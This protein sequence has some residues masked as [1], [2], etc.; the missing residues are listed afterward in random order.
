MSN[1]LII[2]AGPVYGPGGASTAG[3]DIGKVEWG[4]PTQIVTFNVG[5]DGGWGSSS[6]G[7]LAGSFRDAD[8]RI[9][10]RLL[11]SRGLNA[12][13][14]DKI[15]IAGFSA[16]HGLANPLLLSDGDS[17]DAAIL[18]DAC[19]EGTAAAPKAGY[20]DFA[21]KAARGEKLMVFLGSTGQNGPGLP[22]TSKGYECAFN[23][24]GAG[25]A[26]AGAALEEVPTPEGMRAAKCGAYRT[27]DLW[28]LNYCDL[29]AGNPDVHGGIVKHMTEETLQTLLVPYLSGVRSSGALARL[30]A[31]LGVPWWGWALGL[32]GLVGA[33][34]AGV[35]VA[36]RQ[37]R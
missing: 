7:L 2:W 14:Y 6:F 29:F 24:A 31:P 27:G 12:S 23:A 25:A 17:I 22:P 3:G 4:Q 28:V 5:P 10:P 32:A 18:L 21:A 36:R 9:L 11:A 16:F 35:A 30:R 34:A 37:R 13:D 15:A 26:D 33:G 1:W 19:F 8:G 20:R